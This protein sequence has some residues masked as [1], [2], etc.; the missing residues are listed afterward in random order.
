MPKPTPS[1][2]TP[3]PFNSQTLNYPN[4][5]HTLF[6][7]L[8]V[9]RLVYIGNC[10]STVKHSRIVEVHLSLYLC[11]V[12]RVYRGVTRLLRCT[13]WWVATP[14]ENA[15]RAM[16]GIKAC[17]SPDAQRAHVN[18]RHQ[19]RRI[20]ACVQR[21]AHETQQLHDLHAQ[22][23]ALQ[24]RLQDACAASDGADEHH[25]RFNSDAS[26]AREERQS[27]LLHEH[28]ALLQKAERTKVALE[29]WSAAEREH[30]A[31][32]ADELDALDEAEKVARMRPIL[33]SE[34]RARARS[35][36]GWTDF[37]N[38]HPW[39]KSL[40]YTLE[41]PGYSTLALI[42]AIF[43]MLLILLYVV[44][45]VL[46]SFVSIGE[47]S[48]W[49]QTFF[50]F[51]AVI[52]AFFLG[53]FLLRISTCPSHVTFALSFLNWIDLI[54]ILP[55][56][57]GLGVVASSGV[58]SLVAL[59]L[60]KFLRLI[61]VL[62]IFKTSSTM[63][64][65]LD[66]VIEARF[67]VIFL[68]VLLVAET[69]FF[70]TLIFYAETSS[71]ELIDDQYV[72][73]SSALPGEVGS[74]SVFQNIPDGMWWTIVTLTTVG[75][76]DTFPVTWAGRAVGAVT[77]VVSLLSIAFPVTLIGVGFSRVTERLILQKGTKAAGKANDDDAGGSHSK[78][79]SPIDQGV[80]LAHSTSVVA[81][82]S[83][84][85]R[86]G[87]VS[88]PRSIPKRPAQSASREGDSLVTGQAA[89]SG[90]ELS[91]AL[92]RDNGITFSEHEEKRTDHDVSVGSSPRRI[93][94]T[95]ELNPNLSR[96]IA[97]LE[98]LKAQLDRESLKES[99]ASRAAHRNGESYAMS[100]G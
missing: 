96:I 42:W 61:R 46:D 60:L 30:D 74:V 85:V 76:G 82:L 44:L 25:S 7:P 48:Q 55:F 87:K 17:F 81:A 28:K 62:R 22:L 45:L 33:E 38:K 67:G 18:V 73:K 15:P 16:S 31:L 51:E 14:S 29:A 91:E 93:V 23:E 24:L 53:E 20:R 97:E 35:C 56:F 58:S 98:T 5:H 10:K 95:H 21:L 100:D 26:T 39:M 8:Y 94:K 84:K 49:I 68:V 47:K 12:R 37:R 66:A 3:Q 75:Y 32:T 79:M 83:S 2:A 65:L 43:M 19:Q 41:F 40:W 59:R 89:E 70:G 71:C 88:G 27:M 57:I 78:I 72:Y 90:T 64:T 63:Q 6:C 4:L 9:N 34:A 11:S 52:T 77:M 69:I 99:N 13:D 92:E 1:T 54:S 86:R 80:P 50:V 36:R